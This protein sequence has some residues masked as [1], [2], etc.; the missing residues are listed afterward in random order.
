MGGQQHGDVV[1]AGRGGQRAQQQGTLGAVER[2]RGL[3]G[4]DHRGLVDQRPGECDALALGAGQ[5]AGALAGEAGDVQAFQPF[6][7]SRAGAAVG[8]SGE[9]QG[10]GRVLPDLQLGQQLGLVADPAEPV[11]AQPFADERAH[12]VHGDA[13]EPDL[14]LLG[15]QL[16]GQ[17]AEQGGL[18]TAAGTGQGEDLALTDTDGDLDEGGGASPGLRPGDPLWE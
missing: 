5:G 17:T 1:G 18:A 11:A 7:G 4:E 9:Q 10:Q 14:A 15:P 6:A 12:G 3:V 16:P 13:V 2:G 8:G